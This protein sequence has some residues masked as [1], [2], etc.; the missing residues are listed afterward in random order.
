MNKIIVF[1]AFSFLSLAA[2]A[3]D[4]S[5]AIGGRSVL[6]SIGVMVDWFEVGGYEMA[7]NI[8][9]RIAVWVIIWELETK[10]FF[11]EISFS[12]AESFINAL[13]ISGHIQ[14][15]LNGLD[16]RIAAFVAWL[17][18]PEAINIIA[19]AH[20]TSLVFRMISK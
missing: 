4:E 7:D 14:S 19:S 2:F 16:S 17:K 8:L 20:V 1:F 6:D 13:D 3:A 11:L 18:I 15:A 5:S 12:I 10:L 9:E